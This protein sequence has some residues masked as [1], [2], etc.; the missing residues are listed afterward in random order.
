MWLEGVA[1]TW[2]Q[3]PGSER[4][5]AVTWPCGHCGLASPLGEMG[6]RQ[7]SAEECRDLRGCCV[8]TEK[9]K[10]RPRRWSGGCA[11]L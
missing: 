6:P 1:E 4:W 9:A 10:G 5:Q 11:S 2:P 7:V 8:G 3:G